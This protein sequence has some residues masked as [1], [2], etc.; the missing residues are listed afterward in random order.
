L[1]EKATREMKQLLDDSI[2]KGIAQPESP[3]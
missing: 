3:E 2:R 1:A